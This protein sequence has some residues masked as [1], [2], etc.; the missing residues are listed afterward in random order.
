MIV[1]IRFGHGLKVGKSER[2]NRRLALAAAALLTPAALAAFVLG[3]WRIAADLEWTKQFAISEGPFSHWQVWIAC[4]VC[5][6]LLTWVL[7]R[8]GQGGEPK[9]RAR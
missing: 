8:Y 6:Q 9:T 2:K 7:N 1:R 4:G 5:L 3:L